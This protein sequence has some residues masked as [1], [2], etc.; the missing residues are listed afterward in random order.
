[1]PKIYR[2]LLRPAVFLLIILSGARP[3]EDKAGGH[4]GRRLYSDHRACVPALAAAQ[5]PFPLPLTKRSGL[6]P[7]AS[8]GRTQPESVN[9]RPFA[10]R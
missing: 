7:M 1:V 2:P 4:G 5:P 3:F 9:P 10:G 8:R 6:D